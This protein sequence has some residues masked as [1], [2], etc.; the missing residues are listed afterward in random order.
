MYLTPFFLQIAQGWWMCLQWS[1]CRKASFRHYGSTCWPTT[2]TTTSSSRD[3]CRNW[4]TS[5]SWSRSMLSWCRKSKQLRTRHYI[6]FCKRYTG[7][8]TE[9]MAHG[10][11]HVLEYLLYVCHYNL[12]VHEY[13]LM[14]SSISKYCKL[15][16]APMGAHS[17]SC[18]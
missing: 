13:E 9:G 12:G 1:S 4:L 15:W 11:G 3:C 14:H 16:A 10:H 2:R 18:I 17:L 6:R 8:C 7:T 5:G